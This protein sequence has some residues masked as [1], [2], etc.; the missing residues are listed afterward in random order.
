MTTLLEQFVSEGRDLIESASRALLDLESDNR[1]KDQ[2]DQLFRSVHTI[3]GA[4]GLFDFKPLTTTVHAGEDLLDAVRAGDV[5]FTSEIADFML[6]LMDRLVEWL[7]AIEDCGELPEGAQSIGE[8]LALRL[9]AQITEGVSTP[10][11]VVVSLLPDAIKPWPNGVP[12]P[13]G[14]ANDFTL[15]VYRPSENAFFRGDDP[16][17]T[18]LTTP[19][20][21]W[22]DIMSPD[23][24]PALEEFDPFMVQTGFRALTTATIGSL[25][26]HYAYVLDETEFISLKRTTQQTQAAPM[27][28]DD[29]AQLARQV[30]TSQRALLE[31]EQTGLAKRNCAISIARV[32][33]SVSDNTGFLTPAGQLP[34]EE[35]ARVAYLSTWIAGIEAHLGSHEAPPLPPVS[36]PELQ[37]QS[38]D[39]APLQ[40]GQPSRP[41]S[42]LR[43]DSERID[44]LM[45]L[46][47]ELIVAKNAMP[48]LAQK[49]E[50]LDD[51]GSL[52]RE[53]KAQHNTINRIAEELQ[54]AIMQI[55]MVP[56]GNI[57]GRFN[58][59][60]RDMSRKLGKDIQYIVDGEDTEADKAIVDELSEPVVHLIRNAIDHGIEE[61]KTR[62]EGGKPGQGTISVKAFHR[63]ENVVIEISDDGKGI[64]VDRV[65]AKA[66]ERQLVEPEKAASFSRHDKLQLVFLPGLS[67][68]DE[69]SDLSGRG[70]GMDVVASMVRRMGGHIAIES[71]PDQGTR[72]S[73]SLPLSMAVQRLMMIEVGDGL[74]GVPIESVV[75]SQKIDASKIRRHKGA[76]MVV[77]RDR[78]IPLVRLRRLF[79]C[80]DADEPKILS[81]MIV[82]VDGQES[83]LIVD[84]F[85]P[86]VDAIVK[87]MAGVLGRYECFAGTALLGDGSIMLALN[88]REI[89]ACQYH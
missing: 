10:E 1:N 44:V 85:H 20:L 29:V 59:L 52:V 19:D 38:V 57:L 65:V 49:A 35:D 75:E 6:E 66:V 39:A 67:T 69:I 71:E 2:I 56:V 34:D 78:L 13:K 88:L 3:K 8:S 40:T 28:T 41:S 58:R 22:A 68:K 76:E 82:D 14:D 4:S 11:A 26:E 70:V 37:G 54:A 83:G 15:V 30:L 62:V 73:L 74:Y 84:R 47:G 81:V 79:G 32:L 5:T 64:D 36:A 46:A 80:L 51:T 89:I 21:I 24:W 9:R 77:L 18:I 63:E 86:G 25:E 43:V 16:L 17:R 48:F 45:N 33:Q 23:P 27:E 31:S 42:H 60:V 61:P 87:P 12:V 50:A 7:D 55:R 72:I 53:I